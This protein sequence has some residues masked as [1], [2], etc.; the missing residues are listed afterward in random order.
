MP[1]T[2]TIRM[3][4]KDFSGPFILHSQML[5]YADLGMIQRVTVVPA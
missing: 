5:Q 3:R 4:F 1:T 2:T